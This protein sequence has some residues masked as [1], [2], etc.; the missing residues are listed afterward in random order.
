R[1]FAAA[2]RPFGVEGR[3]A[4]R[5]GAHL[6]SVRLV[7]VVAG[8][9]LAAWSWSWSAYALAR[10]PFPSPVEGLAAARIPPSFHAPRPP[11]A[12]EGIDILAPRGTAV[13]SVAWGVVA[14]IETQPRGGKTV[15][16]AGRG[17]LLFFYAH[18][19][20]YASG[21][22]VGQIVHEGDLVGRVGATGNARGIPHLHFEARPLA[23][24]CAPID[25]LPVIGPRPPAPH[26]R[27]AHALSEIGDPR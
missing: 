10:L 9:V 4:P 20:A 26:V 2:P 5:A 12:P 23:T 17:G 3:G 11:R 16:V 7:R 27:V 19:D 8:I 22:H 6:S 18:L 25:P 13:R 21:L 15:L 14:K 24:P 1:P